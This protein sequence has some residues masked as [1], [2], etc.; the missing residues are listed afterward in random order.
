MAQGRLNR[1]ENPL[2]IAISGGGLFQLRAGDEI[3]Y[4]RQGQFRLAEDGTV[5]SGQGYVLQQAG[6]GDLVLQSASVQITEDGAVLDQGRPVGR[7]AVYAPAEGVRLAPTGGGTV[8]VAEAG[9]MEEVASPAL[10]QGMI[11]ASNVQ[12]GD[13][14]VAMMAALRQA[15]GGARLVQVYDDLLGRA[16]TAF[17]Q[18][19][20]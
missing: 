6:G 13:E 4:S 3:V 15:E 19:G 12:L 1:T 17:G 7:I 16:I 5:V 9:E 8:F 14:M 11:E 2:D 18:G 20:K 10:R